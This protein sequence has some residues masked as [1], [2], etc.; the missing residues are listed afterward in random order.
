M[1]PNAFHSGPRLPGDSVSPLFASAGCFAL[2][3]SKGVF[4]R[5]LDLNPLQADVHLDHG[6]LFQP[7]KFQGRTLIGL[8]GSCDIPGPITVV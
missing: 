3:D 6:G 8:V 4:F 7:T 1:G 5:E 2:S